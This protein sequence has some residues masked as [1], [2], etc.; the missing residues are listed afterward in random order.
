MVVGYDIVG[1]SVI[2][3]SRS[4]FDGNKFYSRELPCGYK[5]YLEA[6]TWNPFEECYERYF[7]FS[8]IRFDDKCLRLNYDDFGRYSIKPKAHLD[9][10][11]SFNYK[12]NVELK[13]VEQTE[14][15][16]VYRIL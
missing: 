8:N 9:Y 3:K 12:E 2:N 16:D 15:Y 14:R 13:L 11:R 1:V 6:V 4:W 10:L 7:I 5:Y